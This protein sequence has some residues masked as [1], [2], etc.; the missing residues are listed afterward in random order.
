MRF[1]TVGISSC[2]IGLLLAILASV[3]YLAV[4]YNVAYDFS[5]LRVTQVSATTA[6][7]SANISDALRIYLFFTADDEPYTYVNSYLTKLGANKIPITVVDKSLRPDLA[8][9]YRVYENGNIVFAYEQDSAA[10]NKSERVYISDDMRIARSK[11][12]NLDALV[13]QALLRLQAKPRH[14]Y[15]WQGH[16]EFTWD[17]HAQ[18]PRSLRHWRAL[19]LK[20]NFRVRYLS[21]ANGSVQK[22]PDDATLVVI[23]A[24][25]DE[26]MLVEVQALHTYLA[27]GGKA[28]ILLDTGDTNGEQE[29]EKPL[30]KFLRREIGITFHN[31]VLANDRTY[32]AARKSSIDR[33]Y[34][35]T[36]NFA[37]HKATATL[38]DNNRKAHVLFFQSGYFTLQQANKNWQTQMLIESLETTFSD[39]NRN[40][41]YDAT[42]E[43]RGKYI[44][45]LVAKELQQ[46]GKVLACADAT[47]VSDPLMQNIGN[48]LLLVDS[49][50]WLLA[51]DELGL[52]SSEV[53]VKITHSKDKDMILFY[54][55]IVIAPCALLVI[56]FL[57]RRK[58]QSISHY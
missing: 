58:R 39:H 16:G 43:Q 11:I 4:R 3:N 5:Y 8:Q 38:A 15:F 23:A 50:R 1:K 55:T 47:L 6:K 49:V 33:W 35:L 54:S 7:L 32:V 37:D 56:G 29:T 52:S 27:N 24:P 2:L 45:C 51:A 22:I 28:I 48:R 19:L 42:T 40:F 12:R 25:I 36:N 9:R 14:V 53:D 46:Q 57:V 44:Q 10:S 26:F 31:K 34:V 18:P 41:A 17:Y 20:Q 21:P 13:Q 30:L